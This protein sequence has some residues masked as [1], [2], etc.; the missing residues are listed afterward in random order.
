[1]MHWFA[2]QLNKAGFDAKNVGYYSVLESTDAAVAKLL[3]LLSAR[4]GTHVVAH[5]LGG[6][7][8]L[9]AMAQ[10]PPQQCGRL[11]CL[12]T[13][14]AGSLAADGMGQS[15]AVQRMIGQHLQ[16]LLDGAQALPS[17]LEVGEIAGD[18]EL[19]L[20]R[21][22][23]HLPSPNDGTVSV[24]ETYIDGLTDHIII[25]AS[26]GGMMFSSEAV[27]QSVH[28]LRNGCFVRWGNGELAVGNAQKRAAAG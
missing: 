18:R 15:K 8:A 16:L 7:L 23:A 17:G 5:S 28:F 22:M 12:G 24:G 10:L 27:R 25:H 9:R 4:P 11:V 2:A 26:H 19:G 3:K 21:I 13:P 6:L 1:M 20:G 14:L